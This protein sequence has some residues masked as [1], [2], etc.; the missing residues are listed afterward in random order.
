MDG[1]VVR[2]RGFL[3]YSTMVGGDLL[4]AQLS[5]CATQ[6]SGGSAAG[7]NTELSIDA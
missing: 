7:G 4:L 2:R 1:F 3:K 5:A 6:S